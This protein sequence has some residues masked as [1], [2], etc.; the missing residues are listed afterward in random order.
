M[1]EKKNKSRMVVNILFTYF[2]RKKL[3]DI[4]SRIRPLLIWPFFKKKSSLVMFQ[5]KLSLISTF[6][7]K[8][9]YHRWNAFKKYNTLQSVSIIRWSDTLWHWIIEWF[10]NGVFFVYEYMQTNNRLLGS[11]NLTKIRTSIHSLVLYMLTYRKL[12]SNFN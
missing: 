10:P 3:Y 6:N 7:Q 5:L 2:H 1:I 11:Y 4:K 8:N 12:I 9:H